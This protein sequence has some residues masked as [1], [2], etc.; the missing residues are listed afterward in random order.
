MIAATTDPRFTC[1]AANAVQSFVAGQ[2]QPVYRYFFTHTMDGGALRPLGAFHGLELFFVFGH[3]G[4]TGYQPSPGEVALSDAMIGYWSRFAKTGDPNGGGAPSW[5]RATAGA[6]PYLALDATIAAGDG[7]R[8][9]QCD[10]W[11]SLTR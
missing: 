7:V 1:T 6:D 11:S 8:T 4:S 2:S 9:T 10:F 5:P 3:V